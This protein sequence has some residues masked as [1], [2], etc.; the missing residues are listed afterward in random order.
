MAETLP[1]IEV[2]IT[3]AAGQIGY[4]LIPEILSE[5]ERFS[6]GVGRTINLRLLEVP[7]AMQRLEGIAMEVQDLAY[8]D[9]GSVNI[10]DDPRVAFDGVDF[11]FLVGA[12]P[13]GEGM[14]RADLLEA[15][16]PIFVEQ[17]KALNDKAADNVRVL[18]V[19]NPAN[20][21]ALVTLSNAP[22]IPVSRFSAMSRLDHNRAAGMLA[23][24]L[25][26]TPEEIDRVIIWGNHSDTMVT[27]VSQAFVRDGKPNPEI[28]ERL[29]PAWI[30]QFQEMVA[31]RGSEVIKARGASSA[32][33]AARAAADQAHDW[34]NGTPLFKDW[35]SMGM[36]SH[37]QYGTPRG[38]VFSFPVHT[39][40]SGVSEIVEGLDISTIQ[41]ALA[42]TGAE[43]VS[44]RD[45][46]KQLGM[47][48]VE[49]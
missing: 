15:N 19:G 38:V 34:L 40:N 1:S 14:N 8:C 17:G 49:R 43:L 4:S 48:P 24:K 29:D 5:R 32:M 45:Q 21:N 36:Y 7:G 11:A 20:A 37:G 47:L 16:A 30:A 12:R 28:T 42:K 39:K 3:G 9:L 33:S 25:A 31:K 13:R 27:D 10:T 41:E 26:V 18:V 22:D 2:A 35:R 46:L 23:A 6:G 44:E